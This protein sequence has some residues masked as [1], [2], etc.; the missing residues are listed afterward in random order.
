MKILWVTSNFLHPTNKGGLIRTLEMMRQMSRRHEIHFVALEDPR[1]PEGPRRAPEYS[2]RAYPFRHQPT[3]KQSARFFLE[4]AG[5][6]FDRLPLSI[7]RY[8]VPGLGAFLEELMDREKFDQA[9]CDFLTPAVYFPRIENAVLFQ[10]NVE[11]MIWRRRAQHAGNPVLRR[12]YQGQADR[13]FRFEGDIC[14]KARHIVAVSEQDA[15]TMRELFGATRVSA[16]PTGVDVDTLARPDPAPPRT[17]DLVFVGSMDWLPNVDGIEWFIREVLPLVARERPDCSLAV[18]GRNPP[19]SLEALAAQ[20]PRIQVTGT[21]PDIRPYLW[22]AAI[23][24]VPL[25]IGGGTRLKI[26]EAMA[27]SI[28]V[29][30]TTVGAEGL[31]VHPPEDCRIADTAEEFAAHCLELL[32]GEALRREMAGRARDLVCARFSW[33]QVARGFERILEE[34]RPSAEAPGRADRGGRS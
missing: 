32:G 16:I 25:R 22:G 19:A 1:F 11:T 23:S 6:L 12:Y 29:V 13:M 10:H 5:S 31:S 15:G 2:A 26:Y 33:D 27:G 30:S 18:V 34:T 21:V 24:I 3:E 20:N 28:P 8:N 7:T 17:S 4:I 9:V 14:R